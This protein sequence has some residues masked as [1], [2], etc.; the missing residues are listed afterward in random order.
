MVAT[1]TASVQIVSGLATVSDGDASELATEYRSILADEAAL[2][3]RRKALGGRLRRMMRAGSS[4]RDIA[5]AL[6]VADQTVTN[7]SVGR[8]SK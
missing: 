4:R 5:R 3:K 7:I 6:G 1:G 8:S 2:A